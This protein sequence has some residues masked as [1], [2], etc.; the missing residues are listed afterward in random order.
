MNTNKLLSPLIFCLLFAGV[1]SQSKNN[2]DRK[3]WLSYMDKIARPVLSNLA[4]GRLKEK[5]PVVLAKNID[6]KED[7]T[8]ASYLEAFGRT[9][10]GIS[11]WLNIEGGSKEEVALPNK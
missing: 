2:D 4:E 5:M 1:Q 3:L 8:K 11:P 9:L 6:N 7:R 10:C